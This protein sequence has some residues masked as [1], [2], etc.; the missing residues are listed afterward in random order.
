MCVSPGDQIP[1]L[2][3]PE[4][5]AS[6]STAACTALHPGLKRTWAGVGEGRKRW[7]LATMVPQEHAHRRWVRWYGGGLACVRC[8]PWL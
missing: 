4:E 8:V 3:I 1:W 5:C 7:A 6:T 2:A